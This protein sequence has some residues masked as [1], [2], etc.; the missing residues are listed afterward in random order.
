MNTKAIQTFRSI[1]KV[2][3]SNLLTPI[4]KCERLSIIYPELP[5]LFIKRDDFI[6]SLVWG[7]K[8]RELE[9]IF[10]DALEQQADTIITCGGVQSNHARTTAQIC[11]R[12]G[13]HCILVQNGE[14]PEPATGNAFINEMLRVPIYY[15]NSKEERAPK[16]QAL[17]EELK[18]DGHITY[19]IPLGASNEIGALGFVNAV[20]ELRQQEQDLGFQFDV[21]VHGCSSG[22]TS[23]GLEVGKRLFEKENLKIYSISADDPPNKI[24]KAVLKAANPIMER[25]GLGDP[26]RTEALHIDDAYAGEGYAIPTKFSTEVSDHFYKQRELCWIRLIQQKQRPVSW[27][28]AE[29][30]CSV[31]MIKFCF[32]I[33]AA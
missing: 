21:I 23:A 32:G 22:G 10:A 18:R 1:N 15:V 17:A 20:D 5:E 2:F 14:K 9:Y 24:G 7:N 19:L 33:P 30:E 13:L 16:M 25:L 8:L 29:K 27:I 28:T 3:L 12:L 6:G 31:R 11:K 26:I 4:E